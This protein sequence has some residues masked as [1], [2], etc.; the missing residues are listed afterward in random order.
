MAN[1][2]R[3]GPEGKG[4]KTGRKLGKCL[5]TESEQAQIN[6][7]G[8]GQGKHKHSGSGQGRMNRKNI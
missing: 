6:Q 8:K 3:T 4:P 5:K 1:Q 7:P 2:N